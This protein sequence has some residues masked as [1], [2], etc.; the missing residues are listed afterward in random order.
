MSGPSCTP[1][2]KNVD[3]RQLEQLAPPDRLEALRAMPKS[4]S[5]IY[6]TRNGYEF[7]SSYGLTAILPLMP[8]WI[9]K[10][11]VPL[12]DA[13]SQLDNLRDTILLLPPDSY[14]MTLRGL[15][16]TLHSTDIASLRKLDAFYQSVF[17]KDGRKGAD[18]EPHSPAT[19][20][21]LELGGRARVSVAF[22]NPYASGIV[23]LLLKPEPILEEQLAIAQEATCSVMGLE[24]ALQEYHMS[25]GY[26]LTNNREKQVHAQEVVLHEARKILMRFRESD[27][28]LPLLELSPPRVCWYDSMKRFPL[29]FP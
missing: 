14:H 18:D 9:A 29:M 28:A 2:S 10:F 3:D 20:T 16:R 6:P 13:L 24:P 23:L 21:M 7:A 27:G 11:A 25:I 15:T 5:R 26:L 22:E 17:L 19:R 12:F 1:V 8:E 4:R